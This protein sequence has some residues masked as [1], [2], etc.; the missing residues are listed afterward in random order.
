MSKDTNAQESLGNDFQRTAIRPRLTLSEAVDHTY[1]YTALVENDYQLAEAGWKLRYG[2]RR[3]KKTAFTNDGRA[4]DTTSKLLSRSGAGRPRGSKNKIPKLGSDINW[5]TFGIPWSFNYDGFVAHNTC[6]L[7][8]CLMAW[9]L[10]HRFEEALLPI[11]VQQTEAGKILQDVLTELYA[12]KYNKAR[13]I[14][15]TKVLSMSKTGQHSLFDSMERVFHDHLPELVSLP[16]IKS[17]SCDS[18]LCPQAHKVQETTFTSLVILNPRQID[19]QSLEASMT[20]FEQTCS[21][22]IDQATV[23]QHGCNKFR[24][25][26]FTDVD[27]GKTSEW[28]VCKGKR[29]FG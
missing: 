16:T 29:T 8:T 23:A 15:C 5:K 1:R 12:E 13:W 6:T 4:P 11:E 17:S 9:Y 28:F 18:A 2:E 26:A 21:E 22:E 20:P 7:D 10:L 27:T 14:W 24:K 19:R 3:R 25:Q